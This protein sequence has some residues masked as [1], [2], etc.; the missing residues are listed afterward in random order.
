MTEASRDTQARKKG[1][2]KRERERERERRG[3][4]DWCSQLRNKRPGTR[5]R[6]VPE[7]C[8]QEHPKKKKG[9]KRG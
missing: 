5:E 7:C 2:G 4:G 6:G 9:R 3:G 8:I 1:D